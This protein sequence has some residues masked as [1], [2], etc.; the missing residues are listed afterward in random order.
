MIQMIKTKALI[1]RAAILFSRT[2]YSSVFAS[3]TPICEAF[4]V[5][6]TTI[7]SKFGQKESQKFILLT[8]NSHQCGPNMIASQID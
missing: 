4:D 2:F 1:D 5:A 7:Q 6:V 8:K 3:D